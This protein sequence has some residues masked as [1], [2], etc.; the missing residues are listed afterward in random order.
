VVLVVSGVT[1][2]AAVVRRLEVQ[3]AGGNLTQAEPVADAVLNKYGLNIVVA[4]IHQVR[5]AGL[6]NFCAG[7]RTI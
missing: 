5:D 3:N 6:D 1:A 2:F 4:D 7:T